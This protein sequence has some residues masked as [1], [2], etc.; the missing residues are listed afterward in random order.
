MATPFAVELVTPERVLYSG[1]ADEVTMRTD[2]G[3]I[4]FLAHHEDFI[5]AIDITVARIHLTDGEDA[6]GGAEIVAAVHAGFVHVHPEGVRILAGVAELSGEIDV[7]R[8]RAA[9]ASAEQQGTEAPS[10]S[11]PPPEGTDGPA[12]IALS[13]TMIALLDPESVDA[14]TRRAQARLEAAGVPVTT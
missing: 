10:A 5:G 14:R 8:A 3:E 9:L 11:A 2:G 1:T 12:A 6:E 4:A 7:D 13:P